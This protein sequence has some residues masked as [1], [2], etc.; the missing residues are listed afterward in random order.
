MDASLIANEII[1]SIMKK[2]ESG[3][4]CKLDIE[5]AYDHINWSFLL[6]VLENMGFEKK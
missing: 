3:V 6:K 2:K 1:D 4:R 5:M